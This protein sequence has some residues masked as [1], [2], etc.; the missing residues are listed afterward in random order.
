V[1]SVDDFIVDFNKEEE[2]GGGQPHFPEGTY[3]VRIVA[4]KTG[5]SEDKGTP[6]M[7][8]T[9]AFVEGKLRK[10]KK[11]ISERLYNT[12]KA[13]RRFR[14]LLEA[15]DIKV[16]AKLNISK[17]IPKLKGKELYIALE[18]DEREGYPT[19]SRVGF[20]G[21]ISEDDYSPD[22][23]DDEDEVEEEDEDE[24]EEDEDEDED[25]DEE[26]EDEEDDLEDEDEEEEEEPKPR[27]RGKAKKA[28]AKSGGRSK[29]KQAD[30]D[31]DDDED[32][33]SLD[34]DSM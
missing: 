27:K 2:S 24:V 31:E 11:K 32:L 29:K 16:P 6:Y 28:K 26:D 21:F 10:Q 1:P 5:L 22:D 25:E 23:E 30:E 33:E 34:L 4:A 19:R 20:E 7:E 17:I 8:V 9:F 14:I 3:K 18:D 13:M 15:V 12:P